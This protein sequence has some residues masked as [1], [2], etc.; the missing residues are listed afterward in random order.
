M[1]AHTAAAQGTVAIEN[2]LGNSRVIDYR[3][4]PAATF[5]HPEISS[6]GFSEESAIVAPLIK[7]A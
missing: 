4:I 1:L 5:T 6:V 2:I 3:S 7:H